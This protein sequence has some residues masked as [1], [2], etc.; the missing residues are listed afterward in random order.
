[1]E[2]DGCGLNLSQDFHVGSPFCSCHF[3]HQGHFPESF[4]VHGID[5]GEPGRFS[6]GSLRVSKPRVKMT[7]N[8]EKWESFLHF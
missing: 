6:Q 3:L 2:S 5:V 8:F 7:P 4:A 1:M